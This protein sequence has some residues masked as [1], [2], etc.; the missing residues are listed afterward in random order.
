MRSRSA[1]EGLLAGPEEGKGPETL[2]LFQQVSLLLHHVPSPGI[3]FFFT[4][5]NSEN[6]LPAGTLAPRSSNRSF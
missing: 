5:Q 3:R 2:T 1:L 6:N 4:K